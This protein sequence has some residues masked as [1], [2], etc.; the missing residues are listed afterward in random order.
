VFASGA[1]AAGSSVLGGSDGRTFGNIAY[2]AV[3]GANGPAITITLAVT[4]S[5][6]AGV[7]GRHAAS[8]AACGVARPRRVRDRVPARHARVR[9]LRDRRPQGARPP[10]LARRIPLAMPDTLDAVLYR[11]PVPQRIPA[12]PRDRRDR[13]QRAASSAGS[14]RRRRRGPRRVLRAPSRRARPREETRASAAP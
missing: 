2:G 4:R 10:P 14:V 5:G 9:R 8:M 12:L 7:H 3:D 13:D 1:L 6:R 11:V